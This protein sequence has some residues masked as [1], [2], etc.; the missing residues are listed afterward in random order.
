MNANKKAPRGGAFCLSGIGGGVVGRL[1]AGVRAG[2][3]ALA[4]L[5]AV[6]VAVHLEDVDVVSEPVWETTG[7]ALG[8]D[9]A[10]PLVEGQIAGDDG[11]AALVALAEDLEQQLGAARRQRDIAQLV[12]DQELVAGELA[13]QAE[14]TL[15][16]PGLE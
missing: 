2:S 14:E 9:H 1:V 3:A 7:Q 12:D 16:V 6:A 5:E 10:G 11:G 15:L 13:L 4:L 8:G